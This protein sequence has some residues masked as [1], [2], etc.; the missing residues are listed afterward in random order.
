[1]PSPHLT[2]FFEPSPHFFLLHRLCIFCAFCLECF[3]LLFSQGNS[4]SSFRSQIALDFLREQLSFSPSLPRSDLLFLSQLKLNILLGDYLI[5]ISFTYHASFC[6]PKYSKH[7]EVSKCSEYIE[8]DLGF[9]PSS[10]IHKLF[11]LEQIT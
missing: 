4:S 1:M 7:L 9:S 8:Q 10:S 11:N 2:V 6:T 5:C 3:S